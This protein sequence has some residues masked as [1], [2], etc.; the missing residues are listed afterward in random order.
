MLGRR[1]CQV[2]AA[3]GETVHG[4]VVESRYGLA[5]DHVLGK[6][7]PESCVERNC[8][9]RE[10]CHRVANAA[11]RVLDVDKVAAAHPQPL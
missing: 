2:V 3:D 10:R 9:P 4:G 6:Y 5:C 1:A 7:P 11:P 8:L